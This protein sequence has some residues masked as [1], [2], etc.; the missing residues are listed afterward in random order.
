MDHE[1]QD[2]LNVQEHL[3]PSPPLPMSNSIKDFQK[4]DPLSL[5]KGSKIYSYYASNQ[6]T[7]I[8]NTV[9]LIAAI[10]Y[11][12]LK[13]CI[14]T[15]ILTKIISEDFFVE[16]QIE[17]Q[18]GYVAEAKYEDIVDHVSGINFN[19]A[20]Y[21]HNVETLTE[22][23]IEFWNDWFSPDS[24]KITEAIFIKAKES[25]IQTLETPILNIKDLFLQ[26]S[27]EIST[28]TYNFNLKSN[29]IDF[30]EKLTYQYFLDWFKKIHKNSNLFLFA[31]QS[32]NSE[33]SDIVNSL[34]NYVP[35]DF[36]KI[37]PPC[38][39]FSHENIRTY[40]QWD[41]FNAI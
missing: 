3:R 14:L 24:N 32:P 37:S 28:K 20:S 40:N 21:S 34:S 38:L 6:R 29:Y 16:M 13:N 41:V 7:K 27:Q 30:A 39:L 11:N 12:H 10:G 4:L 22:S 17:R 33:E 5:K 36:T 8:D 9:L 1:D 2:Y 23:I 25:F 19:I 18:L 35:Q 15:N 26:F 31:V